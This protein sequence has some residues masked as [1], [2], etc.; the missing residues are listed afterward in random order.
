MPVAIGVIMFG[1]GINLSFADFKAVF[2]RPKAVLSGLSMQML[3]LPIIAFALISFW[4]VEPVYKMGVVLVAACP[5]GTMS[6]L[7]TYVLKGH[8][9]LSVALTAFNS[10][11]I[12]FSIPIVIDVTNQIFIGEAQII[13]LTFADTLGKVLTSVII[14]VVAGIIF[15]EFTPEHLTDTINRF[16]RYLVVIAMVGM[17]GAVIFSPD[18]DRG[19]WFENLELLVPLVILN[20]IT[21]FGGFYLSRGIKLKHRSNYTIAI[22]LGLQNSAL[23]IYI[24]TDVIEEQKMALVAVLYASFSFILT[25]ALA[26][27]LK[28]YFKPVEEGAGKTVNTRQARKI[29][30]KSA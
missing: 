1:I 5:G 9:A 7:V 23:A 22:E 10:F 18:S 14:P 30:E 24:A 16:F 3:L 21:V 19:M 15:N 20:I 29:P 12:L 4:N 26:Y 2:I 17:V 28:V 6:N 27:L 13:S 11:L 25:L 8:L